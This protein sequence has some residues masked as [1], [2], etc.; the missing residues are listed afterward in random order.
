MPKLDFNLKIENTY[1]RFTEGFDGRHYLVFQSEDIVNKI[2][3]DSNL[4]NRLPLYSCSGYQ[5]SI[6][7]EEI[8]EI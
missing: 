3:S 5:N 6:C 4:E 2:L 8:M 1:V 7:I